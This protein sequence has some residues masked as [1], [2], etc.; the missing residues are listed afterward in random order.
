M[1][2]I[3]ANILLR[4]LLNDHPTQS[5]RVKALFETAQKKNKQYWTTHVIIMEVIFV[6][7]SYYEIPRSVISESVKKIIGLDCVCIE[8]PTL[9]LE[10]LDLYER[11]HIDFVDAYTAVRM[12]HRACST[13]ISFDRDFD[14]IEWIQRIQ[15]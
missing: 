12:K 3:D 14:K 8:E 9:V 1:E 2:C 6:L 13:I 15:P 10:A 5:Q 7:E 11:K 4:F